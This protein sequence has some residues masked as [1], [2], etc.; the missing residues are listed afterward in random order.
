[1]KRC[2][3]VWQTTGSRAGKVCR[4][5][6]YLGKEVTAELGSGAGHRLEKPI[7]ALGKMRSWGIKTFPCNHKRKRSEVQ[8]AAVCLLYLCTLPWLCAFSK[9][10]FIFWAM[11]DCSWAREG[12]EGCFDHSG[13]SSLSLLISAV[14]PQ[15][16]A[17]GHIWRQ[18][19]VQAQIW[20]AVP[21][22][23]DAVGRCFGEESLDEG[24]GMKVELWVSC[25]ELCEQN[26]SC[27]SCLLEQLSLWWVSQQ[28]GFVSQQVL[29]AAGLHV[30]WEEWG[31][32]ISVCW[33][34]F[35]IWYFEVMV[36]LGWSWE[37][38]NEKWQSQDHR[39]SRGWKGH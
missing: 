7:L 30:V 10:V 22:A 26:P 14:P 32:L 27:G 3:V 31:N 37:L 39:M 9:G 38:V 15:P 36:V 20:P 4:G 25:G 2:F 17:A 23:G 35:G 34:W 8:R 18:Q 19:G 12:R 21:C 1:M 5:W 6:I 28:C 16:P 11:W 24:E 13:C 29:G 33:K